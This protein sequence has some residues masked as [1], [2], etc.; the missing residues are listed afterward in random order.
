MTTDNIN[1]DTSSKKFIGIIIII[2]FIIAGICFI[3]LKEKQTNM[4]KQTITKEISK[5]KEIAVKENPVINYNELEKDNTLKKA[6]EKRKNK[7]DIKNSLDMIVN[8]DE[9][10]K[11]KNKIVSMAKILK[12]AALKRGDVVEEDI[13]GKTSEKESNNMES[14]L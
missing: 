8:S 4:V 9:T 12:L 3:F 5:E 2:L 13:A 1:K 14:M 7:Y 6:M 11:I 10:F